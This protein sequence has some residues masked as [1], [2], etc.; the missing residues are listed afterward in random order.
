MAAGLSFSHITPSSLIPKSSGLSYPFCR[1]VGRGVAVGKG[2]SVGGGVGVGV[3]VGV[4]LG[5]GVG[6]GVGEGFGVGVMVGAGVGVGEGV[7][8][9]V[10]IAMFREGDK[11]PGSG[12]L[13][14]L[15]KTPNTRN[16]RAKPRSKKA[17]Y[18]IIL[19]D[20]PEF[21][22]FLR[23]WNA[24]YSIWR[25]T[26]LPPESCSWRRSWPAFFKASSMILMV[27]LLMINLL[28]RK[29]RAGVSWQTC[30][31]KV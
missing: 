8:E 24:S 10:V 14:R 15:R 11:L 20:E 9:G 22:P 3:G 2:V 26:G 16:A 21:F 18:P 12:A 30:A 28:P 13:P 25:N 29:S 1:G 19:P 6:V 27:F 5:V 17:I 7:G 4:G 23:F 31:W